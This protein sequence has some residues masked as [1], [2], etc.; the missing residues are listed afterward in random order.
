MAEEFRVLIVDD[1]EDFVVT[2][3]KR[4]RKRNLEVGTALDG[5]QALKLIKE[6]DFDVVVLDVKMPGMDGLE[7]LGQIK[8]M[9]PLIEV[10]MLT[11][12]ASIE[13]GIEGMKLGA[14]DYLMKPINIDELMAKMRSAYY[15]KLLSEEKPKSKGA[16]KKTKGT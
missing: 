10:I 16:S 13:S 12:H 8:Q 5:A 9:K 4:L 6:K 15:K 2:L 7:I 14:F 11:G 3:E 1:E